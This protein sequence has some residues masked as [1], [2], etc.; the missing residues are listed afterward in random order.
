VTPEEHVSFRAL[1]LGLPNKEVICVTPEERVWFR[2]LALGL[3]NKE[4]LNVTLKS[5]VR[6]GH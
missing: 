1:A 3:P 2:A 4:V 5:T 6:L